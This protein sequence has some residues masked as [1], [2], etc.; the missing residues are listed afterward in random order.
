MPIS[1]AAAGSLLDT[2]RERI[3]VRRILAYAAGIGATVPPAFD[4]DREGGVVAMPPFCVSL[5]WPVVS[6]ARAREGLGAA[7]PERYRGVHASQ[8]SFFHRPIR[9]G[10]DL[11]TRG[12]I[13]SVQP[14]RAG[15]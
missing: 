1:S 10:D 5:E 8:D 15:A 7:G 4:D 14:T 6:G 3:S 2:S 11:E 9:P 12:R 13:A